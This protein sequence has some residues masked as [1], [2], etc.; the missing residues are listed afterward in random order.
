MREEH[1]SIRKALQKVYPELVFN[2][3]WIEGMPPL[4]CFLLTHV[5]N[6]FSIF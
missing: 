5:I 1:G 3:A 6:I 4:S 2:K